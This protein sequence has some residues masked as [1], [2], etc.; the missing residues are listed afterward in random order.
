M[1][2][3]KRHILRKA[4]RELK[5]IRGRHTELISV[6]VPAGYDLNKVIQHLI[7][8]QGTAVNIKDKVNRTNVVDSIERMV[9][10]LRLYKKTPDNGLAIFSGNTLSHEGKQDIKV[11]EIVPPEPLNMRLYRCDHAFITDEL[12]KML[13]EHEL[14]GLIVLD[15]RDASVGLLRGK[16][17]EMLKEMHSTVPGK[18]KTGG[19]CLS[20][21]TFVLLDD[22]ESVKLKDI[23]VDSKVL[24]FDL[25]T[26]QMMSSAVL[27]KWDVECDS[28]FEIYFSGGKITASGD[29]LFF[30]SDGTTKCADVLEEGDVLL[31]ESGG[32]AV[33]EKVKYIQ[34]KINLIDIKVEGGNFIANGVVAHNSQ[35]RFAQLRENA[36]KDFY[37]HVAEFVNAQ[38]LPLKVNLKGILVGGPGPTKEA[39]VNGNYL[40]NELKLKVIAV[41]DLSYTGEFGLHELIDRS[42]DTL[43]REEIAKEKQIVG[44]FFEHLAK[45]DGKGIYG[46]NDVKKALEIGAVDKLLVSEDVSDDIIDKLEEDAG[47]TGAEL[48]MISIETREGA[49]L[50]ELG[51]IAGILRYSLEG[52]L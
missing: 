10:A 34:K 44:L 2:T 21:D 24:R 23:H 49:Q 29:H 12:D 6:Y 31:A 16:A 32:N 50:K 3:K 25:D 5:L 20:P 27:D 28:Y 30:L 47:K 37:N 7:Q 51:G 35:H 36:K 15:N 48:V 52:V 4:L 11:W 41:K 33:V 1:D 26:K 22:W 45:D 17:M 40:N 8:E 46:M 19:Q 18:F 9:R 42:Q 13:E 43:A 39:F 14:F 38:F